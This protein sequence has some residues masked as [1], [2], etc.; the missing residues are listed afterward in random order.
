MISHSIPTSEDANP[1]DFPMWWRQQHGEHG[2]HH[3]HHHGG[4]FGFGHWSGEHGSSKSEESSGNFFVDVLLPMMIGMAAGLTVSCVGCVIGMGVMALWKAMFA[5][6]GDEEEDL[7]EGEKRALLDEEE[8]LQGAEDEALP[9]YQERES[10]YEF[11][12]RIA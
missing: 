9:L 2:H 1:E 10:E 11:V 8:S 7:E 6:G 12:D 4:P 3:G 5:R